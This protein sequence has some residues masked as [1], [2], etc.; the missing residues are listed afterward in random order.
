MPSPM[1]ARLL[2]PNIFGEIWSLNLSFFCPFGYGRALSAHMSGNLGLGGCMLD[3]LKKIGIGVLLFLG[4][5]GVVGTGV[6]MIKGTGQKQAR[7]DKDLDGILEA[8]Q[9]NGRFSVMIARNPHKFYGNALLDEKKNPNQVY[10]RHFPA[11]GVDRHSV[12]NFGLGEHFT[13]MAVMILAD[14]GSLSFDQHVGD[15][16]PDLPKALHQL[17]VQLFLTHTSG[18]DPESTQF[19]EDDVVSS[20][21]LISSKFSPA[22]VWVLNRLIETLTGEPAEDYIKK[23]IMD[24]IGLDHTNYVTEEDGTGHWN[25]RMSDLDRWE[26]TLNSNKLVK[27]RTLLASFTPPKLE[28]GAW[29]LY[30]FGWDIENYRQFRV[31]QT[32]DPSSPCKVIR[33]SEKGLSIIIMSEDTGFDFSGL[34]RVICDIYLGRETRFRAR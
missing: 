17:P 9:I 10:E 7:P 13:A 23:T 25:T 30:G 11:E 4:I 5:L 33:F 2:F 31:E 32:A 16:D 26:M 20:K 3:L 12:F 1:E 22:N 27:M 28:D 19:G 18:L 15:L 6:V 21:P 24:P 14:A 29:G 34:A 8:K